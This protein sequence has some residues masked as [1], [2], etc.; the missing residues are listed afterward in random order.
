MYLYLKTVQWFTIGGTSPPSGLAIVRSETKV[1]VSHST[2]CKPSRWQL[3]SDGGDHRDI[4]D[5]GDKPA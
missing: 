1:V 5:R 3:I 4:T 2:N